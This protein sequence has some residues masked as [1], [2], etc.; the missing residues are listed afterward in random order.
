MCDYFGRL[1]AVLNPFK[2]REPQCSILLPFILV[3]AVGNVLI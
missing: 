1:L 2:F 3:Q